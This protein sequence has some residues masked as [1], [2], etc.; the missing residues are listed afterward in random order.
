MQFADEYSF[1]RRYLLYTLRVLA[2]LLGE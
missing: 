1:C 2:L